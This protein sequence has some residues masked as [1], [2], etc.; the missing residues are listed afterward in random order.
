MASYYRHAL[1][2]VTQSMFEVCC[3][4]IS[5]YAT[6]FYHDKHFNQKNFAVKSKPVGSGTRLS[7]VTINIVPRTRIQYWTLVVGDRL[8]VCQPSP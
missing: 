7:H 1:I 5:G 8:L 3:C 2:A 6:F 4:V